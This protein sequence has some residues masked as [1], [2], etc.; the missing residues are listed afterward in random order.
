LFLTAKGQ[1][2]AASS[3]NDAVWRFDL[4]AENPFGDQP[5]VTASHDSRLAFPREVLRLPDGRLVVTTLGNSQTLPTAL[6]FPAEPAEGEAGIEL[7]GEI[8]RRFSQQFV[9]RFGLCWIETHQAIAM[10]VCLHDRGLIMLVDPAS[11][12]TMGVCELPDGHYAM[13]LAAGYLP[14]A[15]Y[16]PQP[17]KKILPEGTLQ[18]GILDKAPASQRPNPHEFIFAGTWQGHIYAVPVW[19]AEDLA[20]PLGPPRRIY[21]D[22]GT[23]VQAKYM[24]FCGM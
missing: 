22:D 21:T 2:L 5:L 13:S 4:R 24:I 11:Q 6:L 15:Q 10:G 3:G 23:V 17:Y 20:G 7:P 9:P 18:E 8:A 19:P 12:E 14:A 16:L 1:G